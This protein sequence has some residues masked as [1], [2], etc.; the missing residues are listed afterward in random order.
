MRV[1]IVLFRLVYV[2]AALLAHAV[3]V[4]VTA[5]VFLVRHASQSPTV[6]GIS[7]VV[8]VVFIGA[9]LVFFGVQ[10]HAARIVAVHRS[11]EGSEPGNLS[12]HAD[13]LVIYLL[14]AGVLACVWLAGALYGVVERLGQGSAVFG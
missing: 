5:S 14:A 10:R 1:T 12:K 4:L 6:L 13:H 8:S 9:G 7:L 2:C 11:R 3:G